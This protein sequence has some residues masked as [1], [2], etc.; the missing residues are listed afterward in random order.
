MVVVPDE[1]PNGVAPV[2]AKAVSGDGRTIEFD[3]MA[4]LGTLTDGADMTFGDG[5]VGASL[6]GFGGTLICLPSA[7]IAWLCG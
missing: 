4:R 6:D 2:F 1:D 5:A 7:V 3:A